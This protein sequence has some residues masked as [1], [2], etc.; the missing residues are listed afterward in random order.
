MGAGRPDMFPRVSTRRRTLWGTALVVAGLAGLAALVLMAFPLGGSEDPAGSGEPRIT[1]PEPDRP[2][3]EPDP[4]PVRGEA[5]VV[6]I[7]DLSITDSRLVHAG[8]GA[9]DPVPVD[10]DAVSARVE[11]L[12][13]W[14]DR[15]LTDLQEGGDGLVA[16]V[17]LAGSAEVGTLA[18]SGTLLRSRSATYAFTLGVRGAPEWILVDVAVL[19]RLGDRHT[20]TFAFTGAAEPDLQAVERAS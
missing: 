4:P 12:T 17:G 10:D 11:A 5:E 14:L 7:V 1:A 16:D 20:A 6:E 9:N 3:L 15:H 13:A 18:G 2:V 19:D 8:S